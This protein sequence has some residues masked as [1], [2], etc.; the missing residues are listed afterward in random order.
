MIPGL[1][2]VTL[3]SDLVFLV[4]CRRSWAA[5]YFTSL[6]EFRG[7]IRP[8]SLL[9]VGLVLATSAAVA[10]VGAQNIGHGLG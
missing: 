7:D 3:D 4:S 5:A 10:V 2:T 8:I 9:A 6:R 1:P